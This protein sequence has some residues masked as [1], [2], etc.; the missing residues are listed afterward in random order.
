MTYII[1][2]GTGYETWIAESDDLLHWN[3][4]EKIMSFTENTWDA[5]QKA[6][7][8][9]LID[10]T[11]NGS[12][13]PMKYNDRYWI[14]YLG[15]ADKGYEAG[16]LGVGMAYTG[17]M[18]DAG[19]LEDCHRLCYQLLIRRPPGMITKPSLKVRLFMMRIKKA[20]TL[21]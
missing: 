20:V 3:G 21:F 1:F 9:S 2:D 19:E 6:G 7:Y 15:G 10:I 12:Y 18:A 14:S 16:R 11:W 8:P 17:N 13:A 4:S 5:N